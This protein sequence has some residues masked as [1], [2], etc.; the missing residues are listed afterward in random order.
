MQKSLKIAA[1]TFVVKL[2]NR[3]RFRIMHKEQY[4][5]LEKVGITQVLNRWI[6]K[7][8]PIDLQEFV[9]RNY[10]KSLGQL[11]QDLWALHNYMALHKPD[12][13]KGY[14]VEFGATDGL[15]RSNSYLLEKEYGWEG[16]LCE[17]ARAYHED[18]HRNR[19][20]IIDHRCVFSSTGQVPEFHEVKSLELSGIKE[21]KHIGGWENE[22]KDF[23][24][25]EVDTVSLNDLLVEHNAPQCINYVSI[26]TEGSEY[27]IL[28]EFPF[29]KW[30]I[31]AFSIEHNYSENQAKIDQLMHRN[32]YKKVY[33]NQS[34][35]DSWYIRN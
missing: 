2:I 27:E 11:Q 18:L 30:I 10:S 32:G 16:I 29:E 3:T 6:S 15:L 22:R 33:A 19:T 17:P 7:E 35:W 25:Y 21:F 31:D 28:K 13:T 8:T 34:C 4:A 9:L 5:L 20:A 24:S 23:K 26:D 14:F 1:N 12:G